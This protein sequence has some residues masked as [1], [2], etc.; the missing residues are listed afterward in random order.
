MS[1]AE[2]AIAEDA[3]STRI[4]DEVLVLGTEG[5]D[6]RYIGLRGVGTRIWELIEQGGQTREEVISQIVSEFDVDEA[7]ASADAN[8]F[9]DSLVERGIIREG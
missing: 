4:E 1:H 7:T 3:I 9:I 8:G 2:L 6:P 5:E